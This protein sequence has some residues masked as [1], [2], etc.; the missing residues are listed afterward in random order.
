MV[1]QDMYEV[2]PG[3]KSHPTL[4]LRGQE[5][6]CFGVGVTVLFSSKQRSRV[7]PGNCTFH[8]ICTYPTTPTWISQ[9]IG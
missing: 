9:A 2:F 3:P 8:C 7:H 1:I 6:T 4:A 5:G